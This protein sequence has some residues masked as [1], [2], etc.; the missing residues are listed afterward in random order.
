M[1]IFGT[2]F[3]HHAYP[4]R[5]SPLARLYGVTSNSAHS[6]HPM[7]PHFIVGTMR[8]CAFHRSVLRY[9]RF[10]IR[11]LGAAVYAIRRAERHGFVGNRGESARYER[12]SVDSN[13]SSTMR[14]EG[15]H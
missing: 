10:V 2:L 4:R 7:S 14:A 8:K 1:R 5:N 6:G 15:T 9:K 12:V 3:I 13:P 11:V